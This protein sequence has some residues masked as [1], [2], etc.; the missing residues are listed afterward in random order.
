MKIRTIALTSCLG[1]ALALAP[2]AAAHQAVN[3]SPD[4]W[5]QLS[6]FR[7]A[8][9]DADRLAGSLSAAADGRRVS[10][11]TQADYLENLKR[12]INR[13]GQEIVA[14]MEARDTADPAARK[15]IEEAYPLLKEMAAN[16]NE[17][18]N[19]VNDNPRALW[20]PKYL[21][22]VDGLAAEAHQLSSIVGEALK[23]A[24]VRHEEQHLEKALG[25]EAGQ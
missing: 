6:D 14:L 5:K 23:L 19:T 21:K 12:D 18:I 15:A 8:A 9:N 16:T 10:G 3:A 13:M 7:A 17:A 4:V 22:C 11:L 25:V 2:L 1:T 20:Q 24:K